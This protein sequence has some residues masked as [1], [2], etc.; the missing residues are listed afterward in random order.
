MA[1]GRNGSRRNRRRPE[2]QLRVLAALAFVALLLVACGGGGRGGAGPD[3]VWTALVPGGSAA[4]PDGTFVAAT[5]DALD[6][7]V[8]VTIERIED[9]TAEVRPFGG[10]VARS[11]T[12]RV[13]AAGSVA[14]SPATPLVVALPVPADAD[15]DRL[16]IAVLEPHQVYAP[17]DDGG[18]VERTW[19][20]V[21]AVVSEGLVVAPVLAL[22]PDGLKV[23]VVEHQ[24]FDSR[25]SADDGSVARQGLGFV[26]VCAPG[27]EDATETC[28]M[29][30]RNA[31]ATALREAYEALTALGYTDDPR[32]ERGADIVEVVW[33]GQ[34]A[35]ISSWTPGPYQIEL[36]PM[37]IIDN[38]AGGMYAP[39][40]GHIWVA[41]GDRGVTEARRGTIRHEYVH[42]TQYG[43]DPPLFASGDERMASRWVLEG[44]AVALQTSFAE[45][46]RAD[47]PVRNLSYALQRS[48]WDGSVF[49]DPPSEYEAQDFWF[50]L[51]QRFGAS[52]AFLVPFMEEGLRS[53]DVDAVLRREYPAAFGAPGLDGGL[54]RAYWDWARNHIYEKQV[55]LTSVSRWGSPCAITPLSA[56]VEPIGFD[57]T[58]PTAD[59]TV[60]L[61][62]LTT[63]VY[64]VDFPASGG[65]SYATTMRVDSSATALRSVFFRDGS[66]GGCAA[67]TDTS[68]RSVEVAASAQRYYVLVANTSMSDDASYTLAF[69]A[70]RTITID[71]PANGAR[72]Q[73]GS[74][75]LRATIS[76]GVGS[77]LWRIEGVDT[78]FLWTP[79]TASGET[80]TRL[81]C[82][83]RYLITASVTGVASGPRPS[84][85]V[86]ITVERP[87]A[88]TVPACDPDVTIIAPS[89]GETFTSATAVLLRA[90][91]RS[92]GAATFPVQW[93][94][95]SVTG[96]IIATGRE[97]TH[98]FAAGEVV[99]YVTYG[100]ASHSVSFT[101]L[102]VEREAP[103]AT[104]LSPDDG[105]FFGRSHPT[106][107]M[108]LGGHLIR[109]RGFGTSAEDGVIG[110]DSRLT[111]Y[112]RR[113]DTAPAS[114]WE[115]RGTGTVADIL[116]EWGSCFTQA[117]D[118]R[119]RVVDTVGLVGTTI[120]RVTIEPP[121]C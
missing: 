96:F 71:T 10:V 118:V 51:A 88:G 3:V 79:T 29:A 102:D 70:T 83:G 25:P 33:V 81:L 80:Y 56:T 74:V 19:V 23:M 2:Q 21:R 46:R 11:A 86:A 60:V 94:T 95:G 8:G 55:E 17:P 93:R 24:S 6:E 107:D 67:E 52:P 65:Q 16:A 40:T 62:P 111:W 99:L 35:V 15:P 78:D 32:L 113:A 18:D 82:D 104:I 27:F 77:V 117:Y 47:R 97:A 115:Q 100:T 92:P 119:L 4:G 120:H 84:T 112:T 13:R 106:A 68:E 28:G 69:D 31:A 41:I 49:D 121:L 75:D 58:A 30:E 109:F 108:A 42:A 101:V 26:A 45:V 85:S 39:G 87:A 53:A 114:A 76:D 103:T 110:T 48:A 36:R 9:P 61:E 63:N 57:P 73:A 14:A 72:P 20:Y 37:S 59:R 34:N 50:Y 64:R 7:A 5:P 44:Q 105:A 43:Y 90:D 91:P 54:P 98:T 116:F 38:G 22:D 1:N 12:Y 89:G 66:G